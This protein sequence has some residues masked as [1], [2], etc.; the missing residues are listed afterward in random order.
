MTVVGVVGDVKD[1]GLAEGPDPTLYLSQEQHLPTGLPIALVVR[2]QGDALLA[3]PLM[4]AAMTS[5]D[6]TQVVDRFLPMNTYLDASL[7]GDRFRTTLV[8][9]FAATGLLL[10]IV[11]LTGL[12]ARSVGE[13][14]REM[15]VRLALGA[16]P[17]RLWLTTTGDALVSVVTGLACGIVVALAG[18]RVLSGALVGVAPPSPLL[19]VAAVALISAMCAIAAGIAARRVMNIQPTLAL[20][21]A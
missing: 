19:W 4:R 7:S 14:T 18:V 6:A 1:V 15:G 11:G 16:V 10:V 21:G 2:T 13:R 12:T 17:F 8:G 20:R 5:L 3:A 9:V